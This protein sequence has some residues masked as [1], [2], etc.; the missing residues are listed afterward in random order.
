MVNHADVSGDKNPMFGRKHSETTKD[1]IRTKMFDRL[2]GGW[3]HPSIGTK[4][5]QETK[6][7]MSK[8]HADVSGSNNP[9]YGKKPGRRD[10][11][12]ENNPNFKGGVSYRR[13]NIL[14]KL[15]NKCVECGVEDKRVL[16]VHHKD[17]NRKNNKLTNLEILCRN[18]HLL[19][20]YEE[21][22][23]KPK[24]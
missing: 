5:S 17:R 3:K 8:N 21:I 18:C 15:P 12:G 4:H 1:K 22:F 16:L 20:H 2:K 19:E 23:K 9:M 11:W 6:D 13:E 10:Q 7:R 14:T 24:I